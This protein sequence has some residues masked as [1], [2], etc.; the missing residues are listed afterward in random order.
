M[1]PLGAGRCAAAGGGRNTSLTGGQVTLA[2]VPGPR[3]G[4]IAAKGLQG[5]ICWVTITSLP[6]GTGAHGPGR[7]IRGVRAMDDVI[8]QGREP[9]RDRRPPRAPRAP[10]RPLPLRWRVAAA[11]VA[12]T[13]GGLAVVGVGLLRHGGGSPGMPSA[14]ATAAAEPGAGPA[15]AGLV[16]A[17]LAPAPQRHPAIV[18]CAPSTQTCSMR[19]SQ[20]QAVIRLR[21]VE[22]VQ[23]GPAGPAG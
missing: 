9:G 16:P 23:A 11:T 6:G 1:M 17:V 20:G 22:P 12:A 13:A 18:I 14:T 4:I 10:R 7:A 5:T 15:G 8:S 3:N 2:E 21:A 19:G